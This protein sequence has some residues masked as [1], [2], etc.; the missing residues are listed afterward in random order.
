MTQRRNCGVINKER[1][2]NAEGRFAAFYQRL[3]LGD[4]IP[5]LYD[6]TLALHMTL[7]LHRYVL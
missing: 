1:R 3:I 2:S 7:A 4:M 6:T 5:G